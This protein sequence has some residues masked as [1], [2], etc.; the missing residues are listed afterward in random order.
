MKCAKTSQEI[1]QPTVC[2]NS[3][4]REYCRVHDGQLGSS[5]SSRLI[6][7]MPCHV[8]C[9]E[10][11]INK[12]LLWL[13]QLKPFKNFGCCSV[14]SI[15]FFLHIMFCSITVTMLLSC[16]KLQKHLNELCQ[17]C[18]TFFLF[19]H[20]IRQLLLIAVEPV[21]SRTLP[22]DNKLQIYVVPS[23]VVRFLPFCASKQIV[24]VKRLY[25]RPPI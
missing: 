19:V 20:Q 2:S 7:S 24:T 8:H 4:L 1:I 5:N 6:N 3:V 13:F 10:N 9:H 21:A 23:F 17:F 25:K 14:P 11:E 16:I 12:Y 18:G 15:S 22:I